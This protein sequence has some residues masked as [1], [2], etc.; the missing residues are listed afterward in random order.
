MAIDTDGLCPLGHQSTAEGRDPKSE[1]QRALTALGVSHLVAPNPQSKGKIE[2]RLGALQGR[3]VTLLGHEKVQSLAHAQVVLEDEIVPV[4]RTVFSGTD[5]SP[6]NLWDRALQDG[7]TV[8]QAV[9][10]TALLDLHRALHYQRRRTTDRQV[11]FE[12]RS[13]AIAP[14]RRKTLGIIHHPG[15]PFGV[16]SEPPAPL[17]KRWPE[18]LGK[19]FL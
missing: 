12:G 19:D 16:V 18:V 3:G 1:F 2:R 4:H 17:E 10:S 13:W 11:D 6:N 8:I 9:P 15:R 5:M 14:T 7:T